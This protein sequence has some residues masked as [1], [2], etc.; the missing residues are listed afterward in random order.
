MKLF[1]ISLYCF[2]CIL[3]AGCLHVQVF[4]PV[5]GATVTVAP[6]FDR[7]NIIFEGQTLDRESTIG[8]VTQDVWDDYNGLQKLIWM[9]I[10][11]GTDDP[12]IE[13]NKVYLVTASGGVDE[14]RDVDLALDDSGTPV[15]APLHAILTGA[16]IKGNN[17]KVSVL[18]EAMYQA[19]DPATLDNHNEQWFKD[20]QDLFADR[21]VG[22]INGDGVVDFEDILKWSRFDS[23]GKFVGSPALLHDFSQALVD[24]MPPNMLWS[25]AQ[26][27]MA[28][29]INLEHELAGTWRLSFAAGTTFCSDGSSSDIPA[30]THQVTVSITDNMMSLPGS[31]WSA[32]EGWE[33]TGDSGITGSFENGSFEL[34]QTLTGIPLENT[35]LGERDI[36]VVYSGMFNGETWSGEYLYDFEI[37]E[38]GFS[39]ESAQNFSGNKMN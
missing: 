4:G 11:W 10:L 7:D 38:F 24:G 28:S 39:C 18:T 17:G 36:H 25:L 30:A 3:L 5:A 21:F 1:R 19:M 15:N 8:I 6:I 33:I 2:L 27:L 22:D 34:T 23:T 31:E 37:A 16:Q 14:D 12:D 32:L 29:G 35:D 20:E 26:D 13:D 9:G